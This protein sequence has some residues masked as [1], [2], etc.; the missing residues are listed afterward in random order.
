MIPATDQGGGKR[1]G[2]GCALK[3]ASGEIVA[4]RVS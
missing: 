1:R 2:L 3:I 4:K